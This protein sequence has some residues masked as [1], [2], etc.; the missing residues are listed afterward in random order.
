MIYLL[1]KH[2]REPTL[3]STLFSQIFRLLRKNEYNNMTD[4]KR[5]TSVIMVLKKKGTKNVHHHPV[6]QRVKSQP[7]AVIHRQCALKG[8]QDGKNRIGHSV[9]WITWPLV[10]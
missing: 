1:G 7:T 8:I 4:V 9:F 10:S 6:I 2:C 5:S 3:K